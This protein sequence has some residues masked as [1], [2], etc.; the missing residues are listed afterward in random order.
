[1]ETQIKSITQLIKLR[2]PCVV[3]KQYH[4]GRQ[5]V[6]EAC[7][8]LIS[9]LINACIRCRIILNDDNHTICGSCLKQKK[10]FD[11]VICHS[12]FEEPLRGL[13]HAFKYHQALY[14]GSYLSSLMLR[15]KAD[16][17]TKADCFIP[18]PVHQKRLRERGYNH[19]LE[20]T[21]LLAKKLNKPYLVGLCQKVIHTPYQAGLKLKDRNKNL[22]GAFQ[23][24]PNQLKHVVIVDDLMTSGNTA[25][26]LSKAL[27]ATGI[28][29]V[30]VWCCA[31]AS[32]NSH[33]AS[34]RSGAAV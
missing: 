10:Y 24:R 16:I 30:S 5:I 28:Q 21:K 7:D 33:N 6:C 23:V 1:M 12:Q 17:P 18:V 27:K 26:E 34:S 9:P 3:C 11:E 15:H 31:R 8:D 25:N 22:A 20:L 19:A 32:I 14:L 2:A 29:K 4:Q 13:I